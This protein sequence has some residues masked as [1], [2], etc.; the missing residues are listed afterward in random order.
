MSDEADLALIKRVAEFEA[1]AL[2]SMRNTT[3]ETT[4]GLA[5]WLL[6]SLLAINGGA[7]L[8]VLSSDKIS[9]PALPAG[10]F[11]G[12]VIGALLNGVLQQYLGMRH[13]QKMGGVIGYWLWVATTGERIETTEEEH[14]ALGR[15]MMIHGQLTAVPGW[16][17]GLLFV[18]G[19]IVAGLRYHL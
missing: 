7:A 6:A 5:K 14:K 10:L 18:A 11:V 19:S 8:A 1:Q 3:I 12:G 17:S 2:I 4:V 15:R 13:T 9:D 16:I